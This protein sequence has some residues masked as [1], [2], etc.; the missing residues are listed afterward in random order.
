MGSVYYEAGRFERLGVTLW[1]GFGIVKLEEL[2]DLN[3]GVV[4]LYRIT[5]RHACGTE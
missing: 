2:Q 1:E 3:R 4:D 5:I